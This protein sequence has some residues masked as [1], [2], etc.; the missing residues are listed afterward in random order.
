M[1]DAILVVDDDVMNIK[2]IQQVLKEKCQVATAT[3]GQMALKILERMTP[4]LIILD[5]NMPQMNGFELMRRLREKEKTSNI[6]V[7]FITADQGDDIE[8]KALEAGAVDFVSRPFQPSVL[9]NR[10]VHAL[11]IEHYKKKLEMMVKEQA[12][13]IVAHVR[14]INRIQKEVII[15]MA[16]LI[17]SRDGSTGG[18]VKRTC[19]Y[20]ELLVKAMQHTQ[21]YQ[22]ILTQKYVEN[23]CN[24]AYLH[25]IGKIKVSDAILQKPGKLT[26][27][28]YEKMKEHACNGGE[29]IRSILEGIEDEEYIDIAWKVSTYHHEKWDGTGYPE[30]LKGEEIPLSARIMAIADVFDAL[31]SKRCYKQAMDLEEAYIVMKEMSGTYFDPDI[32]NVFLENFDDMKLISCSYQ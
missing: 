25:D 30:G 31:T 10:I 20:V 32:L 1:N 21:R 27:E 6:P 13:E 24:A 15:S 19:L 14:R 16:N 4:D 22:Q 29:I 23:L 26:T 5:I 8:T 11:E 12:N 28:E 2:N 3:S 18:H 7:I 17:E 9:L